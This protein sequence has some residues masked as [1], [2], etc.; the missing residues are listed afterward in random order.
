MNKKFVWCGGDLVV[1]G[2]GSFDDGADVSH[3]PKSVLDYLL[4]CKRVKEQKPDRV[5][6]GG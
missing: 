4:T 6:S 3:L 1:A 2:F 5:K